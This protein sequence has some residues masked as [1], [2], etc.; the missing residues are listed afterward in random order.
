MKGGGACRRG[1]GFLRG[2]GGDE[3]GRAGE[4]AE[5]GRSGMR[6]GVGTEEWLK[7]VWREWRRERGWDGMGRGAERRGEE[8]REEERPASK[9]CEIAGKGDLMSRSIGSGSGSELSTNT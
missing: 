8:R 4:R 5:M 6:E 1:S 9:M 3:C 7:R 2:G